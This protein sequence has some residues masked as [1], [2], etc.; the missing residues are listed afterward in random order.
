MDQWIWAPLGPAD[1]G[2]PVN[3][4]LRA[5][6]G[7]WVHPVTDQIFYV[8]VAAEQGAFRSFYMWVPLVEEAH[9]VLCPTAEAVSF[10]E[11]RNPFAGLQRFAELCAGL[12]GSAF[13]VSTSGFTP[14]LA[15]DKSPLA[16]DLLRQ[17]Q[18]PCVLEGSL[19]DLKIQ[20]E[21]RVQMGPQRQVASW[22]AMPAL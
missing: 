12:G 13:G 6:Q 21:I 18:F 10:E 9:V 7:H 11:D 19:S 22:L 14:V 15:V 8:D 5:D 2:H 20:K 3:V 1:T 16:C 4:L 17:N